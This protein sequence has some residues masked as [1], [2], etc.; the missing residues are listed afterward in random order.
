VVR[1]T[2]APQLGA[3][4]GITRGLELKGNWS[5]AERPP[6]FME[7]FG[8]QGS[9]L[10]NASLRPERGESWDLGARWAA[11]TAAGLSGTVEWSHFESDTRD[12]ILY[13][14]NSQ[15]SVRAQNVSR[16]VVRGEE[17][18]LGAGTPWGLAASAAVTLQQARD[19]GPIRA[20]YGKRLPQRP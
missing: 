20:Y 16:G 1:E 18:S 14:R 5:K 2:A 12:L 15:S 3:R 8:N 9:V 17:L 11:A 19:R 6:D 4:L 13:A 7:L 10:G